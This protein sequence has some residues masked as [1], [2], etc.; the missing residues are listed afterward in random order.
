MN[1]KAPKAPKPLKPSPSPSTSAE[2]VAPTS[3]TDV[4]E[5]GPADEEIVSST[6]TADNA[7]ETKRHDEL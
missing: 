5:D 7:E 1:K 2:T 3:A 6:E 4:P